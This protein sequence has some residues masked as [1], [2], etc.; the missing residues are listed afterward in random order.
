M[1]IRNI[2]KNG[3]WRFGKGQSDYVRNAYAVGLDIKM[4]IQEW[5]GDCFFSLQK[6]I[7]WQVRLGA[8]NQK[9]L[10]DND[11]LTIAKGVEGVLN[12]ANFTS[13]VDG[14]RYRCSFKVYQMYSTE[15]LDIDFDSAQ[16]V[17]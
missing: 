14:R 12:I 4:S 11:I 16:G 1:R 8:K 9:K 15:T 6:G 7:P 10:L 3:D 13:S 2:D 5:F 17:V